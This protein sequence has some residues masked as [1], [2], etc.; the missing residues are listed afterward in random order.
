MNIF[1]YFQTAFKGP[2]YARRSH[3]LALKSNPGIMSGLAELQEMSPIDD[4]DDEP[5]FLLSAGWRSGSTLLQ[6]LVMSDSRVFIWGE[7]YDECGMIQM[8]AES[9]KA[10]RSG[11]PPEEYFYDGRASTQ[12]TEEWIANLFPSLADWKNAQRSLFNVMFSEPAKRSGAERWGIKEVRFTSEHCAYLRWLYPRAKFVFLYRN[13]MDAYRS[14]CRYGRSWYNTFPDTPIFTPTQFGNHW[15][16]LMEG[17]LKD[18]KTLGAL[19]LKYEDLVSESTALDELDRYLGIDVDRS[20]LRQKVGSS[21]RSGKKVQVNALERWL[22]SRAVH[23]LAQRL[24]YD[25]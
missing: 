15:H 6:R 3:T 14:Y 2:L 11:W 25:C 23:P 8:L 18:T 22:L 17:F 24:G 4:L 10:F 21:E 12:L 5:V 9:V 16:R 19:L 20:L 1:R 7:P 13:P